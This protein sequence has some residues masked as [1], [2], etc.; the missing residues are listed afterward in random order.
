MIEYKPIEESKVEE[1]EPETA[2]EPVTPTRILS[3]IHNTMSDSTF[4]TR[5]GGTALSFEHTYWWLSGVRPVPPSLSDKVENAIVRLL[6]RN[7]G[8]T[9]PEIDKIV[10][11]D[12]QGLLTPSHDLIRIIVESYAEKHAE[13]QNGWYLRPGESIASR[14]TDYLNIQKLLRDLGNQLGYI[15]EGENPIIWRDEMGLVGFAYHLATTGVLYEFVTS[16]PHPPEKSMIVLPASRAN[17]VLFKLNHDPWLFE[18]ISSGWRFIKFRHLRQLAR[19]LLPNRTIWVEQL[20]ADPLD[21][22]ELQSESDTD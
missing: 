15:V 20:N 14:R 1:P 9:L 19:S 13:G 2:A 4:L 3:G 17:L 11:T 12:F 21:Y 6:M 18:I 5:Y 22:R 10:C 16:S 8:L 7:P